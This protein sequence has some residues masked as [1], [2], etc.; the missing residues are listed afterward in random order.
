MKNQTIKLLADR[1]LISLILEN[2]TTKSGIILPT[3][4][5]SISKG[6]V[7]AVGKGSVDDPMT[8]RVGDTV[9]FDGNASTT[10]NF[11]DK[12]CLVVKESQVIAIL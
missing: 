1:V 6:N 7:L 5:K 8:V 4:N 9:I 2:N 3:T 12:D 10:V 11:N